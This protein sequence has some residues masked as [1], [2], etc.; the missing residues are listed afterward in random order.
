M[1]MISVPV[2]A[3]LEKTIE[4]LIEQGYG[5]TKA[6]VVRRALKKL[7]EDALLARL[8]EA[9]QDIKEGRVFSG[10]LRTLLAKMK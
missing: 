8:H 7:A 6:G 1:G 3:K 10:D 2:D 5:D 4:S 9:E